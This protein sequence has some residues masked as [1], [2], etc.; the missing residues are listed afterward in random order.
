MRSGAD[1]ADWLDDPTRAQRYHD[2]GKRQI[3]YA[4][5]DNPRSSSYVVGI[6]PNAPQN[7]HHRTAHGSWLDS[8]DQPTANRHVLYG[9]LVGG[10]SS[11]ND[12]YAD[13]RNDYVANEDFDP[14]T[15]GDLTDTERS[16]ALDFLALSTEQS[17]HDVADEAVHADTS[18]TDPP[19][20]TSST[21]PSNDVSEIRVIE[22]L[23]RE[24][25]FLRITAAGLKES[26]AHDVIITKE[27]PNYRTEL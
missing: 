18:D 13:K 1:Y 25:R 14:A 27:A 2:F 20:P 10:P 4:L 23:R 15:A 3:D 17:I 26:H 21:R 24:A 5:G 7:P 16:R 8:L 12:A 6:G 19:H 22:T 11:A 9:A